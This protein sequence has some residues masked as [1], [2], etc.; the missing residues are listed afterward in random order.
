[1][2]VLYLMFAATWGMCVK[3]TRQIEGITID[4]Y[5]RRQR[6]RLREEEVAL[7]RTIWSLR[8]LAG[9]IPETMEVQP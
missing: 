1:M 2:K 3:C 7:R 8:E 9:Q 4:E 6:I 5:F